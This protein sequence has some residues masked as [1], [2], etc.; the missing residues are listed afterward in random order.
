M[1]VFLLLSAPLLSHGPGFSDPTIL[2]MQNNSPDEIQPEEKQSRT[3]LELTSTRW[4]LS[5]L[6]DDQQP[7]L[8]ETEITAS[9][10][11]A[12]MQ[13]SGGCNVY[14]AP[15]IAQ[16]PEGLEPTHQGLT[17][18][19][20]LSTRKACE[21]PISNQEQQFFQALESVTRWSHQDDQLLLSY[22]TPAG[23]PA[24]LVFLPA[25]P[26]ISYTCPEEKSFEV[27]FTQ[28]ESDSTALLI[29]QGTT[30]PLPQ[31]PSGSGAK[32][33]DGKT[34]LWTK[35]NEAFLEVEGEIVLEG[36]RSDSN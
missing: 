11:E 10:T 25:P 7:V 23:D 31:V 29:W 30:T 5:N 35:G 32:Y 19:P 22:T 27:E 2:A 9:F 16:D 26:R 18:G 17:L 21:D 34:T 8:S 12:E 4:V 28:S 1:L 15:I 14:S 20:I 13:G 36:C 6:K 24:T 33:S 3:L